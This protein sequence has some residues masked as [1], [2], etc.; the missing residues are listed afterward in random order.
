[1]TSLHRV[2]DATHDRASGRQPH[3][4]LRIEVLAIP[5]GV[6]PRRGPRLASAGAAQGGYTDEVHT[7]VCSRGAPAGIDG[8][9]RRYR[10][11]ANTAGTAA[12]AIAGHAAIAG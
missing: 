5:R 9:A 12:A 7:F 8:R 6:A 4:R 1:M 3:R 10:G 2:R 11:R